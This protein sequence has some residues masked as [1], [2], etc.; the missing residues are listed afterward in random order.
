M[1]TFI[2]SLMVMQFGQFL[3]H[4]LTLTAEDETCAP[5]CERRR[6]SICCDHILGLNNYTYHNM[7]KEC[8]PI[9]VPNGDPVFHGNL[10]ICVCQYFRSLNLLSMLCRSGRP[11]MPQFQTIFED[12]LSISSSTI[13]TI[14]RTVQRN[15]SLH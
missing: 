9:L 13:R 10:H 1:I 5:S 8:W 2:F 11:K 6:S 12:S 3:D 4:D 15:H 7:P 14:R